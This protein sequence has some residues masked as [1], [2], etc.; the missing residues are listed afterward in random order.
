MEKDCI[1]LIGFMCTGKTTVGKLLK[2]YLGSSYKFI[3]TDQI[4]SEMAGKS[5]SRIFLEDGE[6]R[7]R[8]HEIEACKYVSKLKRTV[9]SCGG[10]IVLNHI[11]IKNL[12]KNCYII[13]LNA[14]SDEIYKRALKD[15]IE[16]RPVINKEDPKQEMEKILE[17]RKPYYEL[18]ADDF[19]ETTGKKIEDIAKEIILKIHLKT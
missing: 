7:F 13:L 3:E 8:E 9:I 4:I 17:F 12:K 10:G 18:A 15:G 19:I 5:I 14:T 16:N 2:D 6:Q 11:N 1:A